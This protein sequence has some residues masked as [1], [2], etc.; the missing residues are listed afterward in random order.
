MYTRR[1][2]SWLSDGLFLVHFLSVTTHVL[3]GSREG[4]FL[5]LFSSGVVTFHESSTLMPRTI[6]RSPDPGL[7]VRDVH[8]GQL[9]TVITGGACAV[10]PPGSPDIDLMLIFPP[11]PPYHVLRATAKHSVIMIQEIDF[12][13]PHPFLAHR[14]GKIL[15]G[16]DA[17]WVIAQKSLSTVL[18]GTCCFP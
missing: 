2:F 14:S 7:C 1:V 5:P 13:L 10:S 8:G 11:P 6:V 16:S 18:P 3:R 17:I 12:I 15:M 9:M 4:L